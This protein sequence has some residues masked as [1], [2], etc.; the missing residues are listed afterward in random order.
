[1]TWE[2][3]IGL[4]VHAELKTQTKMFCGCPNEFG[5][6]PN[7]H[8]CPV[9]AGLP[10]SLP[11][12]NEAAVELAMRIGLALDCTVATNVFSRKNYFYP[13]MPKDYQVSQYD[14][15]I[16]LDGKLPLANGKV[17]GIE[18][19]HLEEDTGKN[20]HIGETGRLAGADYSLVDYN[21]S[22]VPL[23]EI[24]SRPDMRNASEAKAYVQELRSILVAIDASDG[25]ME[26]GSLRV[27]ANISV[28]KP[29]EAFGTRCEIKNVNSL[30]SLVRAIEY[31]SV[32]QIE[33][34]ETGGVVEQQTRHWNEEAGQTQFGRSKEEAYDYRY[35]PE[36]DLVPVEPNAAWLDRVRKELPELPRVKRARLTAAAPDMA[37]ETIAT[38]VELGLEPLAT[39]AIACGAEA[40]TVLNRTANELAGDVARALALPPESLAAL[41]NL[42]TSGALS[43]TQAKQVL[44]EMSAD[45]ADPAKIAKT[46]GFEALSSEVLDAAL[47]SVIAENPDEFERFRQGDQ[48]LMGFFTGQV[49][50]ATKG[51]A[52]GKAVAKALRDRLG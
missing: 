1:M 41:V 50:K 47:D 28:R 44:A 32:R 22:G 4:E 31:E 23:I 52:D 29:D 26:E 20:T 9:C 18:R 39:A 21:R 51:K 12:L 2:T 35:F 37:E 40:K 10:G 42:E 16:N 6:A 8:V 43:A 14:L 36:P 15:P 3:V 17:I 27:D 24:V 33:L 45:Q 25:K 11:V 5:G 49:M 38:V 7:A 30:R 13:D 46:K 19:A 34:L 48:K